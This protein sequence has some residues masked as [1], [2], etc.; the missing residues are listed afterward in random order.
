[1]GNTILVPLFAVL[2]L[3]TIWFLTIVRTRSTILAFTASSVALSFIVF[4]LMAD[5]PFILAYLIASSVF[6][7]A[8]V[9]AW[10][11]HECIPGLRVHLRNEHKII[12]PSG[13]R[14]IVE[15]EE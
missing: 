10:L 2:I 6:A 12:S 5:G 8:W 13:A 15:W 7:H 11:A 9:L 1:M 4:F 14:S 3:S